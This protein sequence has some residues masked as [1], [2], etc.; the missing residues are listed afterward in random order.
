[1]WVSFYCGGFFHG[2]L[3][4]FSSIA[5]SVNNSV[6]LFSSSN[7]PNTINT[8]SPLLSPPSLNLKM[9]KPASHLAW[10]RRTWEQT[11]N[12]KG[13]FLRKSKQSVSDRKSWFLKYQFRSSLK[14]ALAR[15]RE[16]TK[17]ESPILLFAAAEF[18]TSLFLLSPLL[19]CRLK[20][21]A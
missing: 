9:I 10:N 18:S 3:K 16:E 15:I 20:Q 19:K 13:L 21:H 6:N 12:H 8:L 5:I 7:C 2:N 4:H 11:Q 1:M 17:G 14:N